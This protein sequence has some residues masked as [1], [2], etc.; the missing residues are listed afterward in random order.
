MKKAAGAGFSQV[1]PSA[2][3]DR[4]DATARVAEIRLTRHAPMRKRR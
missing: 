3:E 4:A 2:G 1:L